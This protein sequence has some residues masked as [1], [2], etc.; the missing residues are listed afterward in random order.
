MKK[1]FLF[2]LLSCISFAATSVFAGNKL[3]NGNMESQ[4]AWQVSYLNTAVAQTPV[5]TWGYTADKPAA[6]VGGA[7]YVKATTTSG[8]AQY[9]I[10]QAVTLS[11]DSVY[12][13]DAAFK[14]LKLQQSWCEAYVG[15][16]PV[17]GQDYTATSG[18][19]LANYGSWDVPA[20]A[21]E[22]TFKL[23]AAACREYTP[24]TTGVY[25]LV[26]KMGATAWDAF[27]PTCEL[28]IDE[29]SLTGVRT[30]PAVS[31]SAFDAV[32]F[33]TL[34]TVFTNTTKFANSYEW[35]FGDGSAVSTQPNPQHAYTQVGTYSV[36][37][38]ATNEQGESVLVK[39][40]LVKVNE[41]PALPAG[42]LLYGGNM[43]SGNFW[44]TVKLNGSDATTLT[45]NYTGATQIGGAGGNLRIQSTGGNFN[46]AIFQSVQLKKDYTY[47]FDGL[48][49]DVLG[50]ADYWCEGYIGTVLPVDGS[51]YTATQGTRLF[52][53]NTWAGTPKFIDGQLRSVITITSFKAP[54]DGTY[55]FV[56][57]MGSNKATGTN[58]ILLDN[59]TLKENA[60][61]TGVDKLFNSDNSKYNI[62]SA[63]SMIK[64]EGK[65]STIELFDIAGR[66][67][68]SAKA[69]GIF[70]SN[71]L[72]SG[73]YI[74]RVDGSAMKVAVK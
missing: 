69:F 56:M 67:V 29:L 37:L 65:F 51:D 30:K 3:L 4:G 2:L 58:E 45:W 28:I 42:E 35:N 8:N 49:K 33:P 61:V 43:E 22:G 20:A 55:Y 16:I 63:N 14:N 57:K 27:V 31:F 41:R 9:C 19:L 52:E 25:Y 44:N 21:A 59:L 15:N 6:G 5:A 64:V 50:I 17:T 23:N 32:G 34:T 53:I 11:A 74:V 26:V 73:L 48:Y 54:A 1:Q 68:Q 47:V 46:K 71:T 24:A 36:T 13:F 62:S 18:K 38:K 60:P 40:D 66:Q 7:L 70:N 12:T 72:K 39:T 10:Y